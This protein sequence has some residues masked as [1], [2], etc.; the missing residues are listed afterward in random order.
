MGIRTLE[1]SL[2]NKISNYT[3]SEKY[4]ELCDLG[5]EPVSFDWKIYVGATTNQILNKIHDMMEHELGIEPS[6]FKGWVIFMSLGM[7]VQISSCVSDHARRFPTGRWT[8]LGPGSEDKW[9]GTLSWKR[10]GQ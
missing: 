10:E 6:Q 7:C 9:Y 3:A 8:F 1:K 5:G 2:E 4:R